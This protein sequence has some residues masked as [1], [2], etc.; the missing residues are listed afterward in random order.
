MMQTVGL[1]VSAAGLWL[2]LLLLLVVVC[3]WT[4]LTKR[5]LAAARAGR[6]KARP[7]E[8]LLVL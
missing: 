2:A 7:R 1:A 4:A 8:Q 5:V 3:Q 6:A